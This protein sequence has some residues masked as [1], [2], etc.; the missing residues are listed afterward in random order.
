M[1]RY[2]TILFKPDGLLWRIHDVALCCDNTGYRTYQGAVLA[3]L[4]QGYTITAVQEYKG[5]WRD[6]FKYS[7]TVSEET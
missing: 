2:A 7:P 3:A 1:V 5:E 4:R 6:V